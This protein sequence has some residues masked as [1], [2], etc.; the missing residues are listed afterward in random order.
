MDLHVYIIYLGILKSSN[1]SWVVYIYMYIYIYIYICKKPRNFSTKMVPISHT[2]KQL[3]TNSQ[4]N[5]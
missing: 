4:I 2:W 3:K 5:K 1:Y